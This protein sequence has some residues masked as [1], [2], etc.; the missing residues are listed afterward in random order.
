MEP[1]DNPSSEP[2]LSYLIVKHLRER[3]STLGFKIVGSPDKADLLLKGRIKFLKVFPVN[4]ESFMESIERKIVFSGKYQIFNRT[5]H[6]I[7]SGMVSSSQYYEVLGKGEVK[8]GILD[9]G[10]DE[11]LENLAEDVAEK[12]V[13]KL[14]FFGKERSKNLSNSTQDGLKN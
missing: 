1:W 5:G 6:L 2:S 14:M 9:A 4:Y 12:I 7:F 10:K 3:L 8:E 13:D 11:A